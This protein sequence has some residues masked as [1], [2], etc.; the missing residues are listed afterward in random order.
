MSQFD[1]K[2]IANLSKCLSLNDIV[3]EFQVAAAVAVVDL[4]ANQAVSVV[5]QVSYSIPE[6]FDLNICIFQVT[7]TLK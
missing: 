3:F 4:E 5:N 6:H 2:K 7:Y 1:L